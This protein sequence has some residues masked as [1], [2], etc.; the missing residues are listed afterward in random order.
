MGVVSQR[1]RELS[2]TLL[3]QCGTLIAL[4]TSNPRD[5]EY[6][7]SSMEDVMRE[8]VEGLS[9]LSTGEALISGPA[10]PMPAI[11]K[12][13]DFQARYGIALGG[14]DIDWSSE[15]SQPPKPVNLAPY[16]IGEVAEQKEEEKSEGDSSLDSFLK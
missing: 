9:G 10:A 13:H 15:W 7:L 14:K 3:A 5:Q 4:R 1:P 2:Q 12:V 16:L 8:M 6:I 11:V